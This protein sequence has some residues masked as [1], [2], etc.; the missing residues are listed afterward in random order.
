MSDCPELDIAVA[1]AEELAKVQKIPVHR[2]Y[3]AL[4][5][6]EALKTGEIQLWVA[7]ASDDIELGARDIF[8][9]DI[10]VHVVLVCKLKSAQDVTEMDDLLR[11][12]SALKSLWLTEDG[13]LRETELAGAQFKS[14]TNS[15]LWEQEV[16]FKAKAFFSRLTLTYWIE[17]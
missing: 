5:S 2:V 16:L 12:L 15:P 6:L 10:S 14:I 8:D 4:Q 13:Q 9:R 1:L 7:P 17:S 3:N 11:K